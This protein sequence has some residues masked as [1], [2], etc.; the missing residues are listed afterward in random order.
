[1]KILSN[2]AEA[3]NAVSKTNVPTKNI[4]ILIIFL[5]SSPD[6]SADGYIENLINPDEQ[7]NRN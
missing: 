5:L 3:G 1:L 4:W 6:P 2:W 7:I